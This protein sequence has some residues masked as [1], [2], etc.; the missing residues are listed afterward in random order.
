[1]VYLPLRVLTLVEIPKSP[2][3]ISPPIAAQNLASSLLTSSELNMTTHLDRPTAI[4]E[5]VHRA[6]LQTP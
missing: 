5:P 6:D 4:S 2:E 1:L 3:A